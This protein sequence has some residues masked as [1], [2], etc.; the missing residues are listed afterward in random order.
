MSKRLAGC[1]RGRSEPHRDDLKR[2]LLPARLL[3]IA[4]WM[5]SL[6]FQQPLKGAPPHNHAMSA[7]AADR[8]SDNAAALDRSVTNI[9]VYRSVRT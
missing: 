1:I 7:G 3:Y 9:A 5:R 4:E 6:I 2:D 8:A